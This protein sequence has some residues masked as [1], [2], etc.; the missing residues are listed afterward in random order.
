[1]PAML[2]N[3]KTTLSRS[4]GVKIGVGFL[5]GVTIAGGVATAVTPS[6]PVIKACVDNRTAVLYYSAD[7]KCAKTRTAVDLGTG[8]FSVKAIAAAATPSVVS[9]YV[10]TASG[11]GTGSGSI[12]RTDS[13]SSYILTNNHVVDGATS[14]GGINVELHNGD[15][16]SASVVGQ[17]P[18][19]DLAVLK[20]A[21]GNLPVIPFGDSSKLSI[22]DPVVA[23]GSPLGLASTVTSG[24]VSALNR[25]IIA[26]DTGVETYIDAIQ[27]DAAIN[28]GN[29]GGA[30]LD[31]Q[32]RMVGVNAAIATLS[33]GGTSGSIG[34]GFSIPINEAK[35][36]ANELI[37][38]GASTRPLLG[39]S[40]NN[41]Y[42]G[43]GA[44]IN[45]ITPGGGAEKAGI[46]NGS[47]VRSINGLRIADSVSAI[48]RILS[49]APGEVISV[50]VDLPT[51]PS[52]TFKVTL[53]STPSR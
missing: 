8:S 43:I 4:A 53:G 14:A 48:A 30:L 1:M 39:V 6:S 32:G 12:I 34:L 37:T 25:A 5:L 3:L 47:V 9:I 24:I 44:L 49:Y 40:F 50:T 29:S 22:G 52:K 17:D 45:A 20:V 7:G 15:T 27:T 31:G 19:Y 36:I 2:K 42:Q 33:S 41:S 46:P 35:R 11:N 10:T 51:G 18:I 28:P 21:V 16:Y 23:I 13:S 38:T 26:G